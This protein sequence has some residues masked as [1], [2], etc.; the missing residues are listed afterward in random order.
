[1]SSINLQ[2]NGEILTDQKNVVN[3]FNEFF[4]NIGPNLSNQIPPST[5]CHSDY[6]KSPNK[7]SIFITPTNFAE[8]HKIITNLDSAKATD[9]YHIP[10][11]LLEIGIDFISTQLTHIFNHSFETG[12]F[13]DKLKFA[14]VTPIHK[15]DSR[16][17][18]TKYRTISI[19]PVISKI[20]EKLM[21]SRLMSFIKLHKII[22]EHQFGFQPGKSTDLAILDIHFKIIQAIEDKK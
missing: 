3:R 21:A 7:D 1:M 13:P 9:I 4:I 16:M 22:Y 12:V 14:S 5:N 2:I 15:S 10:V 17:S 20:L 18:L 8:I 19:L 11:K 6:L